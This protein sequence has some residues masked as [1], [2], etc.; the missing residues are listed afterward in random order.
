MLSAIMILGFLLV[1]TMQIA[2][3]IVAIKNAPDKA[4]FCLIIPFYVF[5]YARTE[6]KAKVF[7]YAW[8]AGIALIGI[9]VGFV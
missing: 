4:V 6:P 1:I 9:A 8:L 2:I 5:V 7:L 3:L